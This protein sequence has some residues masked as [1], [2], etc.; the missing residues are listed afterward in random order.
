MGIFNWG[1]KRNLLA[2]TSDSGSLLETTT[3]STWE[4]S[5]PL[6]ALALSDLYG[7]DLQL[8]IT[9]K[10]AMAI[11]AVAKA[12]NLI[13][14]KVA[15][16]PLV[17]MT[18]TTPTRR[19]SSWLSQI[20]SGRPNFITLAWIVDG[21]IF[22]GRAWL[23]VTERSA[24]GRPSAFQFVGEWDADVQDGQLVTVKGR[25]VQATNVV[26]IDAPHE[27]ILNFAKDPI[28]AA[29]EMEAAA[30]RTAHNPVPTIELHQTGGDQLSDKEI[31][32]LVAHWAKARRSKDG[33]V[34]F[35]NQ[36]IEVKVHGVPAEQLMIAGRNTAA[37]NV[38]RIMGLSAWAVDAA[39][40]GSSLTYS[41]V[42]ARSRELVEYGLQPYMDAITAR[43]SMDDLLPNGQW[44]RFDTS[45]LLRESFSE[46]MNGYK[47]AQDAQVYT[48]EE[49]RRLEDGI[50]LEGQN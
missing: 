42:P 32:A 14:S 6:T 11:P 9:R 39:V 12:R 24:D 46:R 21:L 38:A 35:T 8:P 27:G 29:A 23:L 28:R 13:C 44:C 47:A 15:G 17:A 7:K 33:A 41:S 45:Q 5:A 4:E 37:L 26:R 10:V 3:L 48:A 19:P 22:H 16:F 2:A 40:E 20:E 25:R 34:G 18:G 43:L 30:M 1:Q 31:D 49:C 36:S 50:P